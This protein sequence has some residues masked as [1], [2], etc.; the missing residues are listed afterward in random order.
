VHETDAN[1]V[2]NELYDAAQ[3]YLDVHCLASAPALHLHK[4]QGASDIVAS[5]PDD[6]TTWDTHRGVRVL[7]VSW[8]TESND[9][10]SPSGLFGGGGRRL[11]ERVQLPGRRRRWAATS[12][13]RCLVLDVATRLGLKMRERKLYTNNG[14]RK[15]GISL[16]K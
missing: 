12:Q 9:T 13:Q 11:V 5:L 8:H 6:H 4:T 1:R 2:S 15:E 16:K 14:N 3:L 10:Y 7:W